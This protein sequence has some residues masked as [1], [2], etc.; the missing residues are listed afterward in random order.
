MN[1]HCLSISQSQID[2][3][4]GSKLNDIHKFWQQYYRVLPTVAQLQAIPTNSLDTLQRISQEIKLLDEYADADAKNSLTE[5]TN[6]LNQLIA[7]LEKHNE[8]LNKQM[9][10]TRSQVRYAIN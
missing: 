10:S 1:C 5:K 8:T 6:L 4:D 2:V 7:S 3:S 9:E